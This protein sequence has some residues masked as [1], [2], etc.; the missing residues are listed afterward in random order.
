MF[1]LHCIKHNKKEDELGC[2]INGDEAGGDVGD[3]GGG[4]S[5]SVVL[6]F[7][8]F[9]IPFLFRF[10]TS[11]SFLFFP[12][13][14]FCLSSYVYL[15][16]SI[17]HDV[18][19]LIFL[20]FCSFLDIMDFKIWSPHNALLGVCGMSDFENPFD[21]H[22]GFD[23]KYWK[24]FYPHKIITFRFL[25]IFLHVVVAKRDV[26]CERRIRGWNSLLWGSDGG[27]I[28]GIKYVKRDVS[29]LPRGGSEQAHIIF[30]FFILISF[31]FRNSNIAIYIFN[32]ILSSNL[33]HSLFFAHHFLLRCNS[34]F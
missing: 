16:M 17:S 13:I 5:M 9:S 15:L 27:G 25:P 7:P 24:M 21:P 4:M 34:F 32:F 3:E 30:S 20:F 22:C 14:F 28:F 6:G 11:I 26:F 23:S 12:S 31:N 19:I 33:H 1:F 10:F 18:T 29:F 8:F 2:R